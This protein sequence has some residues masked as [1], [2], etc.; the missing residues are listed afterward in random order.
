MQ[1]QKSTSLNSSRNVR[2]SRETSR[3][4]SYLGPST[5]SDRRPISSMTS[6]DSDRDRHWNTVLGPSPHSNITEAVSSSSLSMLPK[7]SSSRH[8][9][10]PVRSSQT[11]KSS[12]LPSSRRTPTQTSL[13][14]GPQPRT[15]RTPPPKPFACDKCSHRFERKG[16]LKVCS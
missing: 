2:S 13:D 4:N 8:S 5:S 9:I 6:G 15:P 10:T 16:H 3:R 14:F 11:R 12:V 7:L 1:D